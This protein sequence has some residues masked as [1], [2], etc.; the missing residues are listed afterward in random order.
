MNVTVIDSDGKEVKTFGEKLK[1]FAK[2][3]WETVKNAARAFGEWCKDHRAEAIALFSVLFTL[4]KKTMKT[5]A[6]RNAEKERERIDTTY[7][8]PSTG[9]HWQLRRKPTNRERAIFAERKRQGEPAELILDDL[10]LLR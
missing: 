5:A 10:G 2:K 6:I 1:D 4:L 7:Y 8:D 3:C 9:L